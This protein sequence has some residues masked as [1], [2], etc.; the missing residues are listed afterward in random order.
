MSKNPA[1]QFVAIEDLTEEH[2]IASKARIVEIRHTA[3]RVYVTLQDPDGGRR[4]FHQDK[5]TRIAIFPGAT[6]QTRWEVE[7]SYDGEDWEPLRDSP[8]ITEEAALN[9]ARWYREHV[10]PLHGTRVRVLK[11]TRT[12]LEV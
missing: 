9:T 3:K 2:R 12:V 5:G 8:C 6:S 4:V 11:V 1:A 10:A 7:Y